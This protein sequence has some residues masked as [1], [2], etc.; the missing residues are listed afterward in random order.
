MRDERI[1]QPV[2]SG[3]SRRDFVRSTAAL[4][5]AAGLSAAGARP[6][7]GQ[8]KNVITFAHGGVPENLFP[9]S[10]S[11]PVIDCAAQM[12]DGLADLS[13]EL[14]LIP[15]LAERWEIRDGYKWRFYLRRGVVFHNGE[16]FTAENVKYTIDYIH[17]PANKDPHATFWKGV[18]A[19][20]IN[21]S[22][23]DIYQ[24]T[25]KP[26]PLIPNLTFYSQILPIESLK[27]IGVDGF[28]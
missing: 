1:L 16:K 5:A 11:Q 14:K 27:K 22:T 15:A 25:R 18:L 6:A 2:R 13:R 19:E 12:F 24:A 20:V 7:R 26:H 17:D 28:S 9:H 4:A 10:I 3:L 23:V 8:A 21:D